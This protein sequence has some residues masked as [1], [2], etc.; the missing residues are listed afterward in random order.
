MRNG[1]ILTAVLS[2]LVILGA[3]APRTGP[4][5]PDNRVPELQQPGLQ[6]SEGAARI[7]SFDPPG[8][9]SSTS[10]E[11]PL[12]LSNPNSFPLHLQRLS[13]DFTLAGDPQPLSGPVLEDTVSLMPFATRE[14][15]LRINHDLQGQPELVGAVAAVFAGEDD[16]D[17]RLWLTA[18]YTSTHHP[19]VTATD[20]ELS[21]GAGTAGSVQPPRLELQADESSVY[22]LEADRPL[23][24]VSLAVTN[25][26]S[27]GYLVHAKDL[28]LNLSGQLV[29]IADL[30]PSPV[31]AFGTAMLELE[32]EPVTEQLNAAARAALSDALAGS[33][34]QV[35]LEGG[36]ALDVL[37]LGSFEMPGSLQLHTVIHAD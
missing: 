21:G 17:F 15:L 4:A 28:A 16:L 13:F 26:G 6:V 18:E 27:V 36:L 5:T 1:A 8:T 23:V 29:A 25:P 32:F 24:R 37:G 11:I 35:G 20:Y 33:E 19:W 10:L 2:L 34:S 22:T 30:P 7:V 12:V 14:L 3:C 31:P 9:G